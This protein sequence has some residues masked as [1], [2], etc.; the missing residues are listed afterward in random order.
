MLIFASALAAV[1]PM[2]VYLTIIWRFDRYDREP[3]G[4]L[5]KNY[6]WGALGAIILAL[7]GSGLLSGFFSVFI[8][9][10]DV[11]DKTETIFIAPFVEEIT[12]GFFLLI[13]VKSIKFD[14]MTDGIVYG[15]AIGLGFG[16]TENFLYFVAY[17]S[18]ISE[19]ISIVVIR[20]LFSGVMHCVSTATFGAFL[21]YSK[22]KDSPVKIILTLVGILIAMFIHFAWNFSVSFETTAFLGFLFMI[23]TI[24]IFIVV[25]SFS[26]A[27]ERKIIFR[28]LQ[29]ESG[30][31]LIPEDHLFILIST[32]RNRPGWINESIRKLYIKAAITL[33]FRKMEFK[34]S[35]GVSRQFY[36]RDIE[37]YRNFISNLLLQEKKVKGNG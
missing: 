16:M 36:E 7:I 29:E 2:L 1:I 21:G 37:Y 23:F 35:K 4:L 8:H 28:E 34:K 12:K 22:F 25:Y 19:W 33:A 24:I 5:L 15:G 30:S 11:M 31:G 18:T 27:G 9:S 32:L 14:N 20:T 10:K 3:I 17:G 13:T 6:L 26:V